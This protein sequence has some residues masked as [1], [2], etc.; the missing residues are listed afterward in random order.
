MTCW[1]VNY[2][3]AGKTGALENDLPVLPNSSAASNFN[4]SD[5][6][7]ESL[8]TTKAKYHTIALD[9]NL[10]SMFPTFNVMFVKCKD[11]LDAL[12]SATPKRNTGYN[13]KPFLHGTSSA[14]AGSG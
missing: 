8:A 1:Y 13:S 3:S 14:P 5:G 7:L 10:S 4:G 9:G 12:T 2:W 11:H 6:L